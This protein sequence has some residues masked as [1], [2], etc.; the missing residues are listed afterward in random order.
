MHPDVPIILF[1]R[2]LSE[3]KLQDLAKTHNGLYQGLGIDYTVDPAW[4][5]D[6]LQPY[7]C[8]QGNLDPALLLTT[9]EKVAAETTKILDIL[10]KQPNFIF[11]L[12]HGI[13]PDAKIECVETM[14]KTVKEYR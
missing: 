10:G 7:V 12:G 8:V 1:P 2:G 13:T 3:L 4:A 9:S 6:H 5:R 11:N 14:V